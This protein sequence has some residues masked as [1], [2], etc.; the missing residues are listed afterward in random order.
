M[1]WLLQ[2]KHWLQNAVTKAG[3]NQLNQLHLL[4][5]L[6]CWN[7]NHRYAVTTVVTAANPLISWNLSCFH[8]E[9]RFSDFHC[10]HFLENLMSEKKKGRKHHIQFNSQSKFSQLDVVIFLIRFNSQSQVF[11]IGRGYSSHMVQFSVPSFTNWTWLF[12]WCTHRASLC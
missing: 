2:G 5:L 10:F 1:C 8:V 11:P 7:Q 12:S 4:L 6:T 3:L 9:S